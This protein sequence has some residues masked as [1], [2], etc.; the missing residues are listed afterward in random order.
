MG[1]R[2]I[3]EMVQRCCYTCR[4]A[5]GN[6]PFLQEPS[7]RYVS[8]TRHAPAESGFPRVEECDVCGDYELNMDFRPNYWQT[9]TD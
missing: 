9:E 8:C 7:D 4:Y 6:A 2:S 3:G 5:K 1:A